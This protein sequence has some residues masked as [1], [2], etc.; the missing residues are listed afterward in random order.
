MPKGIRLTKPMKTKLLEMADMGVP[1]F[2]IAEYMGIST[3]R[4]S[5]ITTKYWNEK[6]KSK[7][8]N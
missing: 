5:V 4:V 1:D 3:S 2:K 6:M 8:E 7:D